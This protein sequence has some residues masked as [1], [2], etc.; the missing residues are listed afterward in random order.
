MTNS[1]SIF[2]ADLHTKIIARHRSF[3]FHASWPTV[4]QAHSTRNHTN[5]HESVNTPN[6]DF[7]NSE[8]FFHRQDNALITTVGYQLS[9]DSFSEIAM[10]SFLKNA[11]GEY[12]D[13]LRG[14]LAGIY[15]FLSAFVDTTHLSS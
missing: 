13:D 3:L 11:A 15:T 14:R 1:W 5:L 6:D 9:R 10:P 2:D 8:G 12:F 4:G 7:M